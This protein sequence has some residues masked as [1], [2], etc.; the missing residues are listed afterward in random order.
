MTNRLG[1][2][3][4]LRRTASVGGSLSDE[5]LLAACATGDAV[6]L[7]ELFSRH[8]DALY[9]FLGRLRGADARDLEDLLQRT[10]L[11]AIGSIRRFRGKASVRT[12]LFGIAANVV[13]HHVRAEARRRTFL[14]DLSLV[15]EPHSETPV[16]AVE[17]RQLRRRLAAAL[18]QLGD[19][20][21]IPFLMC[22]VEGLP[23]AE[24]AR[25]LELREGTLWRRLHD[26]R[27]RL[28]RSLL[29]AA[30]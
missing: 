12:W 22:D 19:D 6:A 29:E 11:E 16:E 1:K 28:R 23:G 20:L 18:D 3:L 13:R 26:A 7:A 5:A 4:P 17:R 15:P 14:D 10:F 24:V 8:A 21:R 27:T 25:V 30:T 9:R 2:L